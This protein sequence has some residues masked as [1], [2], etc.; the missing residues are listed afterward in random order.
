M[1]ILVKCNEW[2]GESK[3]TGFEDHFEVTSF[4]FGVGRA[5]SSARGTSAREGN[6]VSVSEITL[7]KVSDKVSIKLFEEALIG[8]LSRHVDIKFVRQGAGNK[9][10]AF[11]TIKLDG[12]GISGFSM[13]SGGDRPAETLTL[14]FDKVEYE[15]NPV[16]DDL[17]GQPLKYS[18]N[19]A[20]A[21]GA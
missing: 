8:P 18:W 4:N 5:I 9:P 20:T 11:I 21:K 12:C 1:P 14:N 10:V 3:V 7:S 17:T 16:A 2:T 13:S 15:Y 19:L 6:I